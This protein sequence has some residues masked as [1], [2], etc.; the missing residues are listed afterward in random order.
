MCLLF[1]WFNPV[2]SCLRKGHKACKFCTFFEHVNE[3]VV[4]V[5]P[6]RD[7]C[8]MQRRETW[9]SCQICRVFVEC[10]GPDDLHSVSILDSS[11]I[12]SGLELFC[13]QG[14]FNSCSNVYLCGFP[15]IL[16]YSAQVVQVMHCRCVQYL[17]FCFASFLVA[18]SSMC[19]L[20][21]RFGR[22]VVCWR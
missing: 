5:S 20:C 3:W 10:L 9:E 18:Q 12:Q 17:S 15:A 8:F 4:T 2:L 7:W 6:I 22:R 16:F 13:V 21:R 19:F 1:P 11:G 14:A